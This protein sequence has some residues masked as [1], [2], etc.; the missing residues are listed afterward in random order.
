MKL[1]SA[2][3]Y[4][5]DIEPL[6][7]FYVDFLG[8]EIEREAPNKFISFIFEDGV[9][10]G[11]KVGDKPREI[12]GHGTIFVEV[13]NVEDWYKKAKDTDRKIYKELI[14]QPW[15]KSFSVLDPDDN[16]VEFLE[17]V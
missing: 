7:E 2:V 3:F 10:L 1:H 17:K 16:K 14:E 13:S 12:G 15:A 9:R 4:S 11:V 6:K 5:T 8:L